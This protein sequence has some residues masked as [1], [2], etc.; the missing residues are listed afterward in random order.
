MRYVFDDPSTYAS[1]TVASSDISKLIKYYTDSHDVDEDV[2]TITAQSGWMS[3]IDWAGITCR[4][5]QDSSS[6]T[7]TTVAYNDKNTILDD[8]M[9]FLMI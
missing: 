8:R 6:K 3:S 7:A 9:V 2:K 5:M 1:N 4:N